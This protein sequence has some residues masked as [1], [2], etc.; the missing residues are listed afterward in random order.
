MASRLEIIISGDSQVRERALWACVR[1]HP[2]LRRGSQQSCRHSSLRCWP[3]ATSI[4]VPL[5]LVPHLER[6]NENAGKLGRKIRTAAAGLRGW[7][8]FVCQLVRP[9][10]LSW[11]RRRA[12]SPGDLSELGLEGHRPRA[13]DRAQTYPSHAEF[14]YSA[15]SAGVT[16]AKPGWSG[17]TERP[18]VPINS[19]VTPIAPQGQM[20]RVIAVRISSPSPRSLRRSKRASTRCG[21]H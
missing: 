21:D 15:S 17:G 8:R 16:P 10:C 3:V 14:R 2:Q 5:R 12:G 11:Q 4:D 6:S 20:S 19:W 9:G 18:G 7:T 1:R 13:T